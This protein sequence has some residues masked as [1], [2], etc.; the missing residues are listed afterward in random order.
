MLRGAELFG[1]L[2]RGQAVA[3][4]RDA[5]FAAGAVAV[6]A[7][8]GPLGAALRRGALGIVA[9]SKNQTTP[10]ATARWHLLTAPAASI[11]QQEALTVRSSLS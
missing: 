11:T 8:S 6:L 4:C 1:A 2:R 9:G 10:V 3:K 5:N 7:E